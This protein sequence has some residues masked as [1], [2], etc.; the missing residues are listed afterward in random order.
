M[1]V[2]YGR[3]DLC[4]N[5]NRQC[6]RLYGYATP[7]WNACMSQPGAIQDCGGTYRAPPSRGWG[8]GYYDGPYGGAPYARATCGT[9]RRECARLHGFQTRNWYACMNQPGAR[10]DCGGY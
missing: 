8:G 2:Q 3:R 9:W 4:E 7:Q 5:W 10:R 6:S 1:Q